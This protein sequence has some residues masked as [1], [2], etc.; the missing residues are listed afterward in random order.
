MIV[1]PNSPSARAQLSTAPAA[2]PGASIGSVT[3]RNVNQRDAPRLAAAWS[4][5][6]S[7]ERIA[8]STDDDQKRH[9]DERLGDDHA[10]RGEGQRDAERFEQ[11]TADDAVPAVRKQQRNAAGDRRQHQRQNDQRPQQSAAAKSHPREQPRQR[12]PENDA[13]D[14]RRRCGFE[15]QP[16]R[17]PNRVLP[18][19][20]WQV[21]PGGA[22]NEADE[23]EH[24]ERSADRGG[25]EQCVRRRLR[26]MRTY[27]CW[28]PAARKTAMPS[29]DST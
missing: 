7:S 21:P 11:P 25:D 12:N 13:A 18:E 9:R 8:A 28:K 6:G 29:T 26:F 27:G 10:L 4:S 16:Q 1:A 20:R 23:R 5:R 19:Q 24:K 3:C 17:Q 22:Y 2:M 15:R 14:G